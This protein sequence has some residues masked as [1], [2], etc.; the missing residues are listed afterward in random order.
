MGADSIIAN[1]TWNVDPRCPDVTCIP[2][3]APTDANGVTFITL[4]GSVPGSPGVSIRDP[5]RRWGHFDSDMPVLAL[6]YK[7]LGRLTSTSASGSYTLGIKN[8]DF[9]GGLEAFVD[10]G[11]A[12]TARDWQAFVREFPFYNYRND[13]DNN[14]I[15]NTIDYNL[16]LGHFGHDCGGPLNP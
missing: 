9:V 12:V 5:N 11:E 8:F 6:G 10:E 13:F 7:L 3:D 15:V 4:R 2:A 14:G 1:S 16:F